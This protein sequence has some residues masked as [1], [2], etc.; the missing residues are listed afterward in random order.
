[1]IIV[2]IYIFAKIYSFIFILLTVNILIAQDDDI[3]KEDPLLKP[4]IW[5]QLVDKPT[6]NHFWQAYF[7][8]DIFEL[9]KEENDK[10]NEWRIKL[11]EAKNKRDEEIQMKIYKRKNRFLQQ[12]N[13]FDYEVMMQNPV[14]NFELLEDYFIR[15]FKLFDLTYLPYD[16]KHPKGSYNKIAWIEDITK[17]LKELNSGNEQRDN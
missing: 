11:S 14:K 12:P 1:M 13:E 4:K 8:K 7:D 2:K 5:E 6:N 15:H 16:D 17:K 10:Y 3:T 9:T